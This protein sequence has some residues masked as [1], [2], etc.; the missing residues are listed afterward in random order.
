LVGLFTYYILRPTFHSH[1]NSHYFV[2]SK[3]YKKMMELIEGRKEIGHFD[4]IK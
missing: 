3:I 1:S 4:E 2:S